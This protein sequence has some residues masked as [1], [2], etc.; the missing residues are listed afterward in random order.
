MIAD[1]AIEMIEAGGIE[2]LT[3]RSLAARLDSGTMTLYT[4]VRN[5]DDLLAAVVEQLIAEMDI[6]GAAER[7]ADTW[8]GVLVATLREY[9]QIAERYPRSFELL[10]LAPYDQL[11]IAPHLAAVVALV[12]RAGLTA[13][14]ARWALSTADAFA[15]GFLVVRARTETRASTGI[16][17]SDS[18]GE[19]RGIAALHSAEMFDLGVEAVVLGIAAKLALQGE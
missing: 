1:T 9:R 12:E 6:V 18:G 10:A 3:M 19:Y 11:P 15:T 17:A 4:H 2:Q 8:Q 7:K 13:D 16:L 14:A 5:R